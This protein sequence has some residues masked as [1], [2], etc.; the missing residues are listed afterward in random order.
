MTAPRVH[1]PG[2]GWAG[3]LPAAGLLA[4]SA[5]ALLVL[6]AMP[7]A[8]QPVAAV[9]APWTDPATLPARLALADAQYL[10][11]TAVP[12]IAVVAP[13]DAALADRLRR[14]GAILIADGSAVS[15]CLTVLAR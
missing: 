8:G 5:L 13:G 7:R 11:P 15:A 3:L 10:G 9:F 2:E 12:W 6:S 14:Q 1:H 4:A